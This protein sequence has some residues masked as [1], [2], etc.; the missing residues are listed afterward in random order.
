MAYITSDRYKE[1]IYSQDCRHKLKIWFNNIE[2][3]DADIYCEKL[4]VSSRIIPNGSKVFMLENFISKEATLVL[5]EVD[6]STIKDQVKISIGTLVDNE[7]EYVPIGIFNIQDKPTTDNGKTTIKLRDNSVKFDFG[8]NGKELIDNNG[9]VASLLQVLQD[10]CNQAGVVCNITEFLG[11]EDLIGIY[12]NTI[13]ARTYVAYIAGQA[14]AIPTINRD[15]ELIFIYINNLITHEIPLHFVEKYTDGDLYKISRVAYESGII[16]IENG[17]TDNDTLFL[18]ASN[19]YITSQDQI[20]GILE[21]VNNFEINSFS[22]G[23][24][25]GN[26][27]I[28]SYDLI[29]ITDEGNTYKTLATN[30]LTYN[31]VIIQTFATEIG[32]EERKENVSLNG[33]N[34]FKKWAKTEIDRVDARITQEVGRIDTIEISNNEAIQEIQN[35]FDGYTPLNQTLEL[36]KSVTQIQTDT[37]SKIQIDTKLKDGSVTMLKSTTLTAD[38]EGLTVDKDGSK[39][40]SN[41]DADGLEII[42]KTGASEEVLLEAKYDEELGETIVRS[43]NM[44]VEKY[45]NIGTHSRIEDYENGTGIFYIG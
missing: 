45:L 22:T 11:S 7:Y 24:I 6:L 14:G 1:V 18:D 9:G 3:E 39:T 2:L 31:G 36:E 28:D 15:G 41:L 40:K 16:K 10:I 4:T 44:R 21:I 17:T 29:S 23:K 20:D 34:T 33:E 27:A 43:R 32:L 25:I 35:K 12:D 42:D 19:P 30:D 13:T 5:H 8:Y 26:P 37:Y 38:D